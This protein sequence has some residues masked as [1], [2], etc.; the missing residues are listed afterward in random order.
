[1]FK[2]YLEAHD[3]IDGKPVPTPWP[4]RVPDFYEQAARILE[5]VTAADPEFAAAWS[6]LGQVYERSVQ[7]DSRRAPELIRKAQ[8]VCRKALELDDSRADAHYTLGT[9]LFYHLW[10]FDG[11]ARELRRAV[12]I[13][14][15]DPY[16]QSE[17]A[18]LLRITGRKDEALIEITRALTFDP[19]SAPLEFQIGL[20]MLDR[21]EYAAAM[22]HAS[23]A[24]ALRADYIPAIW[25]EGIVLEQQQRLPEAEAR[26]RRALEIHP[27]DTRALPALGHLLGK[28]KRREEAE[29]ILGALRRQQ[30]TGRTIEYWLALI[31]IGLGNREV[32]LT[33]LE[34]AYERHDQSTP[35][36]GVD[37]RLDILRGEP[38]FVALKKRL[39]LG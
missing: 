8:A 5:E 21:K 18:D 19:S 20:H 34:Q 24:L 10:D 13:N 15:R 1:L 4:G 38:R 31:E 37:P 7:F 26:F 6:Y 25:L 2:R 17:L 33:L 23:R 30:G 16:A 22:R 3:L 35:Y 11:A 36:M 29:E 27:E 28:T 14:P 39:K 9:I 32:A 12:E